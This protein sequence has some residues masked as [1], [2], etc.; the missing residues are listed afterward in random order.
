MGQWP[1]GKAL[2]GQYLQGQGRSWHL[3]R[4]PE[5][6]E[7]RLVGLATYTFDYLWCLHC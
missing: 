1:S 3:N 6:L 5:S 2:S 7:G 4:F